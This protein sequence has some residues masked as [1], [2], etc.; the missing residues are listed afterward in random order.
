MVSTGTLGISMAE[1]TA[2][3][4]GD[5]KQGERKVVNLDGNIIAVFNIAG[6]FYAIE[7]VCPHQGGPVG[8]GEVSEGDTVTCPLHEW[9]FNIKTGNSSEFPDIKVK[10]FPVKVVGDEI[11]VVVD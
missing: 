11:K 4:L 5:I 2:A 10:T 6:K 8:E 1:F 3:K 9:R 7:N